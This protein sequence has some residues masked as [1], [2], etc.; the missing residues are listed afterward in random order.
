MSL[1]M[2]HP[3][4]MDEPVNGYVV[5]GAVPPLVAPRVIRRV[6][7]LP[8]NDAECYPG[9]E[10]KAWL[11]PSHMQR[12]LGDVASG[13]RASEFIKLVVLEHNGWVDEDGEP[14]PPANEP[15][16]WDA[17]P[18]HLAVRTIT[19]VNEALTSLPNSISAA[20]RN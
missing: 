3:L 12:R 18:M 9:F 5:A 13:D 4:L 10:I 11:N 7:W 8:L 16:F 15:A 14:Y 2:S 1:D 6:V 19:V 17:I 20:K